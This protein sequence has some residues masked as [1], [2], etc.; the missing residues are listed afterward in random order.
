MRA[1]ETNPF[2]QFYV[3]I[4]GIAGAL[5][6]VNLF[7]DLVKFKQLI[8]RIAG[9]WEAVAGPIAHFLFGW[10]VYRIIVSDQ[11]REPI[12]HFLLLGLIFGLGILRFYYVFSVQTVRLRGSFAEAPV[13]KVAL[14]LF[15]ITLFFYFMAWPV[16]ILLLSI[17]ILL[18]EDF[19]ESRASYLFAVYAPVLYFALLLVINRA[20]VFAS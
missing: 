18:A 15:P 3:H 14:I 19:N 5:S 17:V 20:L 9:M 7:D 1:K 8:L 2:L 12:E 6:L 13:I 16:W 11:I 4:T 10:F